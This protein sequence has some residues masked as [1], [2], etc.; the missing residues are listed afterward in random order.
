MALLSSW[1]SLT[2]VSLLGVSV[3]VACAA[4]SFVE[5]VAWTAASAE[6]DL[7]GAETLT[8]S[9]VLSGGDGAASSA[10][11]CARR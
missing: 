9:S 4:V 1:T 3:T 2:A 7:T 11:A 5:G 10:R 6:L 8:A